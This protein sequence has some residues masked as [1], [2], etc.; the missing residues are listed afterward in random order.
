MVNQLPFVN[1]TNTVPLKYL[2]YMVS[3]GVKLFVDPRA[4]LSN[5]AAATIAATTTTSS[6]TNYEMYNK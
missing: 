2:P 1:F 4:P 5:H 6:T 3:G